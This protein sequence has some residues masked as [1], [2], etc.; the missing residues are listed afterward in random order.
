MFYLYTSEHSLRWLKIRVTK[1]EEI[2]C[3]EREDSEKYCLSSFQY[4][5]I[6]S[7]QTKQVS[8]VYNA[9]LYS[10]LDIKSQYIFFLKQN[11]YFEVFHSNLSNIPH[12]NFFKRN[13]NNKCTR[14]KFCHNQICHRLIIN[15]L[16]YTHKLGPSPT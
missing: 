6:P 3:K 13:N 5:S 9:H 10:C 7:S 15:N 4:Y 14:D 8:F 1:R 16:Y 2:N 11:D 12:T